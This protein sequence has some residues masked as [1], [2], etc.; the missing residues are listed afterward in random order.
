M[1]SYAI[2]LADDH[3]IF[4]TGVK[5]ILEETGEL[6]VVGE[7]EDGLAL[8]DFLKNHEADMVLLDISMPNLRG[9]EAAREAKS[10]RPD[11]K[12]LILTMHKNVQYL[13][14]SVDAGADG[15]LLKEDTAEELLE[16]IARL[17]KGGRYISRTL[18]MDMTEDFFKKR[19]QGPG[20][21]PADLSIR[22][23]EILKFVAE[24][25]SSKTIGKLLF[26]SPRTAEHHRANLKKK[27][28]LNSTA[29]LVKYAIKEGY[30]TIEEPTT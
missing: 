2:V 19:G 28:G 8:L 18:S 1:G 26:I 21:G 14:N 20:S 29:E 16:A 4:R 9:I 23:R 22:E 27:L 7:A 30:T 24:G 25:K 5:K 17:R 15:Y 13:A 11:I 3:T 10:I 6:K 12:I